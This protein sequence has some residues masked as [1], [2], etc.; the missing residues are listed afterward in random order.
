QVGHQ[1]DGT[2][3]K[4]NRGKG[5]ENEKEN[6]YEIPMAFEKMGWRA[7]RYLG[8]CGLLTRRDIKL[9]HRRESF[10]L[11]PTE[12]EGRRG[13]TPAVLENRLIPVILASQSWR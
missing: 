5:G 13:I 4:P 8:G 7:G 10:Y 2:L 6:G 1:R 9:L 12:Y 3:L 11:A